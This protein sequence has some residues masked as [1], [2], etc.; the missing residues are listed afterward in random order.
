MC[1]EEQG[2]SSQYC[3]ID[4]IGAEVQFSNIVMLV[5]TWVMAKSL[6]IVISIGFREATKV[7]IL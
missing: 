7:S 5:D 1:L 3:D 6:D 4:S 2:Q